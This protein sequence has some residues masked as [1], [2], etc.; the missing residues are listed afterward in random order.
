[1]V[2]HY[3]GSYV[4]D[5]I[6]GGGMY[7]KVYKAFS[8]LAHPV[9]GKVTAIKILHTRQ[10]MAEQYRLVKQFKREAII[11][12]GLNYPNIVRT[13]DFGKI[14]NEYVIIMEYVEGMNLKE[15]LYKPE[16][17]PLKTLVKICYEAGK[18]IEHIHE[19]KIV[20]KDIKPDNILLSEDTTIVKI[21]DFGIAKLSFWYGTKDIFPKGGTITKYENISYVAPEQIQ[22]KSEFSSDTYSLGITLDEVIAAKLDIP[23]QN[24]QD[25]M[26]RI[27]MRSRK[28]NNG[29]QDILSDDLPI[30][31]QLKDVI[32]KATRQQ[33][34]LR[35][36]TT[37]EL[38]EDLKEFTE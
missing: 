27:D 23:E 30:P 14:N 25:Y 38:L 11:T 1:M 8:V 10:G 16:K 7:T 6:I 34:H 29:K 35:Y 21:T 36:Q 3:F 31:Q 18:G 5:Q 28:K 15:F 4:L 17:Y 37:N 32:K 12:I 22:G 2:T 20:H 26:T 9:Y 24:N 19:K 13:Y 33:L